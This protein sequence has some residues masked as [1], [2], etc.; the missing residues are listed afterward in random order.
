MVR[1]AT[2]VACWSDVGWVGGVGEV[3]VVV[4]RDVWVPTSRWNI[5]LGSSVSESS[6]SLFFC[7]DEDGAVVT[8][9]SDTVP[10]SLVMMDARLPDT[11][12]WNSA[13]D[14]LRVSSM[15]ERTKREVP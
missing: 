1:V 3:D 9:T 15:G 11:A 8:G 12:S 6:S 7:A 10:S 14:S 4:G 5:S 2:W 13:R